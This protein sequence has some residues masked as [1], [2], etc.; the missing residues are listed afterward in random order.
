MAWAR[1][2]LGC[3]LEP[4][5]P[6]R[7]REGHFVGSAGQ[8]TRAL[9]PEDDQPY[10]FELSEFEGGRR[11]WTTW[12]KRES[13]WP[14]VLPSPRPQPAAPEQAL[15]GAIERFEGGTMLWL[16]YP[17]GRRVILVLGDLAREW[18]EVPD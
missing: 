2:V 4:D 14:P 13:P 10:W 11:A 9:W 17:D 18:R 12:G 8:P 1:Q 16:S 6:V 15:Q 3:P 7:I 5:R